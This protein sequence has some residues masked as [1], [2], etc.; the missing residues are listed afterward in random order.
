MPPGDNLVTTDLGRLKT[1]LHARA[2]THAHTHTHTHPLS[3]PHKR[4]Q[5]T[6]RH[7]HAHSLL[8]ACGTLAAMGVL[9]LPMVAAVFVVAAILGDFL[10]FWVGSKVGPAA[11]E[12]DT[13]SIL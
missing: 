3:L 6:Y 7:M 8:F 9:Q 4:V 1:V 2:R 12:M 11:F 10:N 13:L 5:Y